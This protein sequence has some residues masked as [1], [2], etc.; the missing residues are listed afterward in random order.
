MELLEE[1][2]RDGARG[3]WPDDRCSPVGHAAGDHGR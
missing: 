3:A 1:L 2:D